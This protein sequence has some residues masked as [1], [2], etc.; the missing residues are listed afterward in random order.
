[1]KQ[2][3][4]LCVVD[5]FLGG[6]EALHDISNQLQLMPLQPPLFR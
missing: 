4:Y 2:H 3:T 5:L 1:M 6:E